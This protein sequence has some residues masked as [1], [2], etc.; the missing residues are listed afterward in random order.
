VTQA[1]SAHIAAHPTRRLI[2]VGDRQFADD[3]SP[4]VVAPEY[5]LSRVGFGSGVTPEMSYR[6]YIATLRDDPDEVIFQTP[7]ARLLGNP[8]T[9]GPHDQLFIAWECAHHATCG[10]V[11][12]SVEDMHSQVSAVIDRLP[13]GI[14]SRQIGSVDVKYDGRDTS[15]EFREAFLADPSSNIYWA[16]RAA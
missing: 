7:E 2:A 5:R 8:R 3:L 15:S 4:F 9:G 1:I 13:Y 14:Y 10:I 16:R 12:S 11:A 6:G